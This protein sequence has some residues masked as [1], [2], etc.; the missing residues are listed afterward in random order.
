M[1]DIDIL[2]I[3]KDLPRVHDALIHE[4]LRPG[5]SPATHER[6]YYW[7]FAD[8][9]PT[10]LIEIHVDLFEPPHGLPVRPESLLEHRVAQVLPEGGA[11][12]VLAPADAWAMVM[13]HFAYT[14]LGAGPIQRTWNDLIGLRRATSLSVDEVVARMEAWGILDASATVVQAVHSVEPL[15]SDPILD[16][17]T[18]HRVQHRAWSHRV[19]RHWIQRRV[20]QNLRDQPVD[21]AWS[22]LRG[23][24][25]P[26]LRTSGQMLG[27]MLGRARL[28]SQRRRAGQGAS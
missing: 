3:P 4:G 6:C 21:G 20:R 11:F 17:L 8:D 23:L 12:P 16:A 26:N 27:A 1:E 9:A 15:P 2:I 25:S 22:L 5:Y 28:R 24:V 7:C 10:V 18:R 13:G 14:N 19:A